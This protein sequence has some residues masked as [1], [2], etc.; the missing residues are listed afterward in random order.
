MRLMVLCCALAACTDSSRGRPVD[1]GRGF[2]GDMALGPDGCSDAAKLV[3]IVDQNG[4][5]SSFA[6]NQMDVT[7]STITKVVSLACPALN[8]E[9]PFSMSVDR[10]AVAWVLYNTPPN[11][12]AGTPNYAD[13][14]KVDTMTG[15]CTTTGFKSSA[16]YEQFGM[17]FVSD[18]AGSAAETLFIAGGAAATSLNTNPPSYLGSLNTGTLAIT[19][20]NLLSGRPELTGT[21]DAKLWAFFPDAVNPR[22]AQLDKIS[23][24]ESNTIPLT[25]L[26]GE[27]LAWAFAFW[28][29]D[30]WVFLMRNGEASTTVYHVTM[31]GQVSSWVLSGKVIVGAGVSTCAPT[32]PIL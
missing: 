2:M 27:P 31:A 32:G 7:S 4:D 5:L 12:V 8:G 9:Q 1:L 15:K 11:E 28:G 18:S 22:I 6:P 26:A 14:F 16:G 19:Q 20:G 10:D 21:G 3:Y 25:S 23:A 30:F 24:T 17:G 13:V 29:G